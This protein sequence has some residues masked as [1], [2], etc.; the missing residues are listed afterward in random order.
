VVSRLTDLFQPKE[1]L[2][3]VWPESAQFSAILTGPAK[4]P[5][6]TVSHQSEW[7][8]S[9][10]SINNKRWRGCGEERPSHTVGGDVNFCSHMENSTGASQKTENGTM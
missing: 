6:G 9:K 10:K 5:T 8:S 3:G 2:G 4:H 1:H 7:P